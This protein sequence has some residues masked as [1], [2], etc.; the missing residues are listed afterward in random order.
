MFISVMLTKKHTSFV[1]RL[2]AYEFSRI[3]AKKSIR[4]RKLV[5]NL[6]FT[7]EEL[8]AKINFFVRK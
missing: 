2:C 8:C 4:A 1:E 5:Q 6:R 3:R 7:I